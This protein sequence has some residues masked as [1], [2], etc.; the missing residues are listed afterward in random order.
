MAI[1]WRERIIA[2]TIHF[3]VTLVVAGIAAGAIFLIW[4]PGDFAAMVGGTRLFLLV[5][6]SDLILGPLMSL[7]IYSSQ[8]SRR[9]LISDYTI[10]AVVQL[11]ALIY[12][13]SIVANS[14]PVFIAFD[15]DRLEIVAAGELSSEDLSESVG[16]EFRSRSWFGPRLC[17]V[18]RKL[19]IQEKNAMMFSSVTSGREAYLMPKYYRAYDAA[20][21]QIRSKS[22]TIA[23]LL[24]N[25]GAV[26]PQIEAAVRSA[27]KSSD[28][29]RWLLV[30][31]RF[32]FG[33][34]LIDAQTGEP[35][36]YL[37]IDP[38]WIDESK[39]PG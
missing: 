1:N 2:A 20:K 37:A 31:H 26:R 13:V 5:S 3:L 19:S 30:H 29:L 22:E 27:G 8:K 23:S 11:A 33:I 35:L 34:A 32:G 38:V 25:S 16:A 12:G 39:P 24:K 17:S 18:T 9:E 15:V 6:V 21:E 7:V 36:K 4:F 10:V 14:R 28:D